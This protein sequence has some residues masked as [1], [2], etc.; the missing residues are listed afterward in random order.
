MSTGAD[1]SK[2]RP[3]LAQLQTHGITFVCRYLIDD[4]RDRGKGL[5]LPEARQLAAWGIPIV[6]NFEYATR[7]LL[8][9]A[10]GAADARTAKAELERLGA[11]RLDTYFS[12]DY[13]VPAGE[14]AGVLAYLRGA[15]SVL[16][17]G[18][19]GAYGNYGLISYLASHGIKWL[20]QTYAWSYGHWHPAATI[21]QTL[22]GAFPG[23]FDG[24]R[25]ES[26]ASDFGQWTL[27]V[28][29]MTPEQSSKLD[30]I[31]ALLWA[32]DQSHNA[33]PLESPWWLVRAFA[34]TQLR[35]D[36]GRSELHAD[37]TALPTASA[38][39]VADAVVTALGTAQTEA[40]VTALTTAVERI[41][42]TVTP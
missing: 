16:G 23:E 9:A 29:D 10:Q 6:S 18:R 13:E 39:A 15:G 35:V 21:R 27:E 36:T 33:N 11:P 2:A 3:T 20:W 37:I 26:M 40:I 19:A 34:D 41:R 7:P 14:Y 24:D 1:Y 30:Q 42:L 31:H 17:L 4:A 28:D 12:F 25:D 38:Q 22:N 32:G 5:K 8:T